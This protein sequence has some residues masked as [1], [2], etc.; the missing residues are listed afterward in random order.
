ML[1][2]RI[3][4]HLLQGSVKQQQLLLVQL[5]NNI[6]FFLSYYPKP[7]WSE[8][9]STQLA[10]VGCCQ[11]PS[12]PTISFVAFCLLL[13]II[14]ATLVA[15]NP[16]VNYSFYPTNQLSKNFSFMT[17]LNGAVV[18]ICVFCFIPREGKTPPNC[19]LSFLPK[20]CYSIW[21]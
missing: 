12:C 13:L 16:W 21:F 10:A 18:W 4:V 9:A 7:T 6:N 8:M 14:Y 2:C 11:I 3:C 5:Q 15:W 17:A 1:S 19:P 20:L